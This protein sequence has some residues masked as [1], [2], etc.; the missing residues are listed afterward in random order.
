MPA[1]QVAGTFLADLIDLRFVAVHH[2]VPRFLDP[3]AALIES[4]ELLHVEAVPA[5]DLIELLIPALVRRLRRGAE[6][7][8]VDD[9]ELLRD[10]EQR[11][12]GLL[13][14]L[15]A[16]NRPPPAVIAARARRD[17]RRH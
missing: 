12:H 4:H 10:T 7:E 3:F 2:L 1:T 8:D 17:M 11:A 16:D 14:R 9:R 6:A 15:L 13:R 5:A